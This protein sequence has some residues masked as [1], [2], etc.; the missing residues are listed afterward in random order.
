M[1]ENFVPQVLYF[2]NLLIKSKF[3]SQ[4]TSQSGNNQILQQKNL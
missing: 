1:V 4:K 2:K 3:E